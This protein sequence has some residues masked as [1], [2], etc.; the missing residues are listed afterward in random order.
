MWFVQDIE[1]WEGGG[2]LIN[3]KFD[4][5]IWLYWLRLFP[6]WLWYCEVWDWD[7]IWL[8]FYIL[9]MGTGEGLEGLYWDSSWYLELYWELSVF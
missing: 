9:K 7:K 3:P 6:N 8:L 4:W 2:E 1:F 5:L